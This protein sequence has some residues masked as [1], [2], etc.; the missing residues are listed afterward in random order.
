[1][2]SEDPTTDVL[3]LAIKEERKAPILWANSDLHPVPSNTI[4][5]EHALEMMDNADIL[6]AH[7]ASFE[8]AILQNVCKKHYDWPEF[9]LDKFRCSAAKAAMH[10]LPRA[11]GAA[12][13]AINLPQQK[14]YEG[15]RV[16]MKLCRPRKPRKDEDPD[17]LYWNE[18][19]ADLA[20][21]YKYCCQDVIAEEALSLA[22][23]D[24][25]E[26]ELRIWRLDQIIN[27][28]GIQADL[29]SAK[30]MIAMV[31]EHEALLLAQLKKLT[32]GAVRTGKQVEQLRTYLRGLGVDL[33][34]LTAATVTEALKGE[35]NEDARKILEI[36]HSLGR[37]S[38]AKYQSILDRASGD[39]R[40]R[41]ALLY[42]GAGTGRWSG[43]G[44]QP[45]NFPSRIK[46]SAHPEEMLSVVNAGGL[47]LHNALYDDDPMMT[48]GAVT[49][50]VL[51]AAEGKELIVAD[52][53]AIEGRGL[54]WLAGEE[55][56]LEN[57]RNDLDV[58]VANAATILN[59]PMAAI[60]KEER[61]K[62]G[63]I[64]VLA[65][66][67]G[68]SVGAVRKFGGEGMSDDEIKD[69]IVYPWREAHPRTVTFWK[70]LESTCMSAVKNPGTVFSARAI[71]FRV[72]EKFLLCRLPSGRMLYYYAPDIQ[73]IE[74]SWGDVLDSVTY[75]TVD[76]MTHKWVRVD[77]YGGKL[78]ENVTQ[79]ICRDL[80]AEAMLRLEG[81][82]Y[83]IV[84]T[85]HDEIVAEV[86]KGFGS[87]EEFE[88][89]MCIVPAWA[90]GFPI[91]AHGWRGKRY[92]K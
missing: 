19:P 62:I 12:C 47:E 75:K 63:K 42:H 61:D 7:N 55:A 54:A 10:A 72:Q 85:V 57:Y 82:N 46:I 87:V 50:S 91:A 29:E 86:P 45:Q 79:A 9:P 56:E 26:S 90:K 81:I 65:C 88:T 16:M 22:L 5:I 32:N 13:E 14:D 3:C 80:M 48:A 4:P 83:P 18:D 39:G 78:A 59:K 20:R 21:L 8:Y 25:P 11:L 30:S 38:S 31:Q 36:R 23:R 41:G 28:R 73:P 84:L 1:V 70:E 49:R 27:A 34:D 15:Y 24:L 33:P 92:K 17:G 74:K 64:S 67:Y 53:S 69:R 68:G 60:T 76:S 66:G 89:T 77:T 6:E 58:Y 52:F 71:G 40:V 35:I 43:A 2:Y 51:I 37:S 44:I